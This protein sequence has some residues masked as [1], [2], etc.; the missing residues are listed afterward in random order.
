MTIPGETAI[1]PSDA[2]W[3]RRAHRLA[4]LAGR[5]GEV[6]VAAIVVDA[7]SDRVLAAGFNRPI[8]S[9]DPTAHAE[10]V[11]IR[12]ACARV[13]NYRLPGTT[14]YVTLEPCAMCAGALI[15]ARIARLVY[16]C[17]EPRSG[18]VHSRICLLAPGLHN[19]TV[20]ITTGV[21]AQA[22]GEQL[23]AFFR[24]RRCN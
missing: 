2:R 8:G 19:H 13:G 16:A 15:H 12:R 1:H 24:E 10:I 7:R 4:G 17:A 9:L 3:M 14:L 18:A 20:A 11:A 5:L 22:C 21:M 6:P 23:R